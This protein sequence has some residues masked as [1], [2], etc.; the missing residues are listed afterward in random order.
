MTIDATSRPRAL[1][2]ALQGIAEALDA[3]GLVDRQDAYAQKLR[4][5]RV[6]KT[7]LLS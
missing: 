4:A 6:A 5:I 1:A 3:V 2:G 7:E